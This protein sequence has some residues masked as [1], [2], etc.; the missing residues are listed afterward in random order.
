MREA[1]PA[2][3]PKALKEGQLPPAR[4]SK[5]ESSSSCQMQLAQGYRTALDYWRP[6]PC[7]SQR[8]HGSL[9]GLKLHSPR[10]LLHQGNCSREP[11]EPSQKELLL[12]GWT[13]NSIEADPFF[14]PGEAPLAG[15]A[16]QQLPTGLGLHLSYCH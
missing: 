16:R 3:S 14:L 8:P 15:R 9:G 12:K 6:E 7:V 13:R 11:G 2:L 10:Q 5:P 1:L 4:Q